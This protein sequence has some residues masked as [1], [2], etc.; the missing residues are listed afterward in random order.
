M[1]LGHHPVSTSHAD[2]MP[3]LSS[4]NDLVMIG[5]IQNRRRIT[6]TLRP[7]R[8]L[9]SWMPSLTV[10][11][12]LDRARRTGALSQ[13]SGDLGYTRRLFSS[14]RAALTYPVIACIHAAPICACVVVSHK[15]FLYGVVRYS[16]KQAPQVACARSS[17][18]RAHPN[19]RRG[20]C[21]QQHDA[22]GRGAHVVRRSCVSVPGPP[23]AA[24]RH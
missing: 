14:A 4:H 16:S 17:A 5:F 20:G 6:L 24:P 21:M 19:A 10:C 22:S 18:G 1:H 11:Y 23:P 3:Y 15:F 9:W 2:A 12:P 13:T 8:K 7:I